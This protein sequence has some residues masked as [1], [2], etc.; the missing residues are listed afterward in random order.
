MC[1]DHAVVIGVI[2]V[3]SALCFFAGVALF[4]WRD[5]RTHSEH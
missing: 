5:S 2:T 3:M 1:L 4:I